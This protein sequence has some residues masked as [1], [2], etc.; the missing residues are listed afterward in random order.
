MH[1]AGLVGSVA[2]ADESGVLHGVPRGL[3]LPRSV[4]TAGQLQHVGAFI[5]FL[6]IKIAVIAKS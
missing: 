2:G 1:T 4:D 3:H 6:T 5:V